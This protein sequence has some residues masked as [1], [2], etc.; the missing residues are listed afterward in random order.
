MIA[1]VIGI[2][3]VGL[4]VWAFKGSGGTSVGPYGDVAGGSGDRAR[5]RR[6]GPVG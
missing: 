1:V 6:S 4:A 2:A 3:I 5:R